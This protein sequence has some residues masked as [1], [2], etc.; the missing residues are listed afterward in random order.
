MMEEET[1]RLF[2]LFVGFLYWILGTSISTSPPF[3][4]GRLSGILVEAKAAFTG[5]FEVILDQQQM[6]PLF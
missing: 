1:W 4:R 6:I 2:R 3:F 5:D